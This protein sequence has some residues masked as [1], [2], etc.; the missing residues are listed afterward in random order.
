MA[1]LIKKGLSK[2]DLDRRGV[3]WPMNT[4]VPGRYSVLVSC[5]G[6]PEW[7][8]LEGWTIHP[9]GDVTPSVD[10][11]MPIRKTDG[12]EIRDCFFHDMIKLEGWESREMPFFELV[13]PGIWQSNSKGAL[14][15]YD[16]RDEIN[17]GGIINV[18]DNIEQEYP[19]IRSLRFRLNDDVPV[20]HEVFDQAVAFQ[21]ALSGENKNTLVHCYA[22]INRS[23]TVIAAMMVA[24]GKSVTE[25][26]RILP[27]KPYTAAMT[28]SL[29]QWAQAR[30][31]RA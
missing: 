17:L 18:A 15:A 16:R 31:Y 12:T 10:H 26:L 7:W 30:G 20:P 9:N 8:G 28:S 24:W 1:T 4:S 13:T 23:T 14:K 2:Y 29:H 25:A 6:C 5:P 27:R 3:W 22:G 19:E 11:S 21:K